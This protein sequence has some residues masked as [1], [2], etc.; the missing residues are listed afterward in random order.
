VSKS[1]ILTGK[2]GRNFRVLLRHY[3][4][5]HQ[6][7]PVINLPWLPDGTKLSNNEIRSTI[8]E[9]IASIELDPELRDFIIFLNS[10]G[11]TTTSSCAGHSAN[12]IGYISFLGMLTKKTIKKLF[13]D[14]GFTNVI[15]AHL[16]LDTVVIFDPCGKHKKYKTLGDK[17]VSIESVM[18]DVIKRLNQEA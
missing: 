7:E 4:K 17:P 15:V 9:H 18:T 16:N 8:S 1:S 11:F 10:E 13:Q 12:D 6:P 3:E 5:H 14:F 2:Q